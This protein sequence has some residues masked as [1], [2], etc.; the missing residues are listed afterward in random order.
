[1]ILKIATGTGWRFLDKVDRIETVYIHEPNKPQIL[2]KVNAFI[3]NR[4]DLEIVECSQNPNEVY[5]LNDE[6]KTI[7]RIN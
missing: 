6:G 5:L 3:H 1:M 2:A 7:E 4:T